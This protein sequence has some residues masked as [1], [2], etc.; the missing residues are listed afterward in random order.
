ME[1][2]ARYCARPPLAID[3]LEPLADGRILYRFK[4]PWRNG[5]THLVFD[6]A[7][8]IEKLAALVPAPRTHLVRYHGILAPAAK[9]RATIVPAASDSESGATV[10]YG[11]AAR[12]SITLNLPAARPALAPSLQP[13]R[14]RY[15]T[16]AELM[17]RVFAIDV[18]DCP[19]CFARM[20]IIATIH[21]PET[22]RKILECLRLPSRSPPLAP[23][24]PED[25]PH[26]EWS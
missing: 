19:R 11:C 14:P 5:T 3:R 18:L 9:W 1:R 10:H 21:P 22:T 23:A 4:R 13:A 8:F 15:Y 12:S 25:T 24:T 6:P 17:R 20:R 16:W 2:L 7:Q 26:L